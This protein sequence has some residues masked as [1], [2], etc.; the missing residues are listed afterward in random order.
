VAGKAADGGAGA[1]MMTLIERALR[2][3]LPV[4]AI[5][6]VIIALEFANAQ[7]YDFMRHE[8]GR[9]G[10]DSLSIVVR[11]HLQPDHA[12]DHTAFIRDQTP[13]A[14]SPARGARQQQ[15]SGLWLAVHVNQPDF[16]LCRGC[17]DWASICGIYPGEKQQSEARPE[18]ERRGSIYRAR[19]LCERTLACGAPYLCTPCWPQLPYAVAMLCMMP[20]IPSVTLACHHH[21]LS[22]EP[23][24]ASRACP[25][26]ARHQTSP[27]HLTSRSAAPVGVMA[28]RTSR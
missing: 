15:R 27:P 24:T 3:S 7:T 11:D 4:A 12:K 9:D 14:L 1:F 26:D 16:D 28:G 6:N 5:A 8:V 21:H 20:P 23:C 19:S 22:P 13:L 10:I 17:A 18:L 2:G 25:P